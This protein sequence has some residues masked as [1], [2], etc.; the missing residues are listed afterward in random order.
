MKQPQRS[1]HFSLVVAGLALLPCAVSAGGPPMFAGDG[2]GIIKFLPYLQRPAC[3]SVDRN[4]L[5]PKAATAQL[6]QKSTTA[7]PN[8]GGGPLPGVVY[9]T[10]PVVPGAR[11]S[12]QTISAN[13][14][15]YCVQPF[16][17]NTGT[18]PSPAGLQVF[19]TRI[20]SQGSVSPDVPLKTSAFGNAA[21]SAVVAGTVAGGATVVV[22]EAWCTNLSAQAADGLSVFLN[23]PRQNLLNALDAGDGSSTHSSAGGTA[24]QQAKIAK[25]VK[26]E[27]AGPAVRLPTFIQEYSTACRL[28]FPESSETDGQIPPP[29][30]TPRVVVFP[31]GW[32]VP[33]VP[34]KPAFLAQQGPGSPSLPPSKPVETK[35]P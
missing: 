24:P 11:V 18:S 8:T 20:N 5:Y 2:G 15:R 35:K 23:V 7:A 25:G 3:E 6:L 26:P 9:A 1:T 33:T 12:K 22:P 28:T 14:N 32:P 13:V 30:P 16:V 29:V 31:P 10:D 19:F 4:T 17:V 34:Q 27:T 21:R